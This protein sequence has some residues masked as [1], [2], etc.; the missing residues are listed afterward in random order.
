M[1]ELQS[2]DKTVMDEELLLIDEQRKKFLETEFTPGED[3]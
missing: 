3:C 1:T 2:H